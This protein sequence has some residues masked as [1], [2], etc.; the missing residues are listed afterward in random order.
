MAHRVE[1]FVYN[2]LVNVFNAADTAPLA[3]EN[4][5]AAGTFDPGPKA[6]RIEN[7]DA[8]TQAKIVERAAGIVSE[9]GPEGNFED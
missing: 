7:P 5:L 8:W 2:M 9:K 6:E 4:M 1:E 3:I